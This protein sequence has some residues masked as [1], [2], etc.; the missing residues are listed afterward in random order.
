M[1]LLVGFGH[2]PY[3]ADY[4]TR[5]MVEQERALNARAQDP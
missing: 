2:T 5:A 3:P 4:R 1:D